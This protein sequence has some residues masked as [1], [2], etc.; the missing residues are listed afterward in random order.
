[1]SNEC[2]YPLTYS[3]P[4]AHSSSL[5]IDDPVSDNAVVDYM[6]G[7]DGACP[8]RCDMAVGDCGLAGF[9]DVEQGFLFTE[10]LASGL[11]DQDIGEPSFFQLVEDGGHNLARS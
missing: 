10:P 1:M 9:C 5:R 2:I 8:F 7:D 3:S 11:S 6:L 4:I